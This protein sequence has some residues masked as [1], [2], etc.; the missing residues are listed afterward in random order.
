VTF[1]RNYPTNNSGSTPVFYEAR[2]RQQTI[3]T[4]NGTL[5]G[6]NHLFGATFDWG[7][8][9][10]QSGNS[11]PFDYYVDF[12]ENQGRRDS[13]GHVNSGMDIPPNLFIHSDPGQII[14][15]AVNNFQA[16]TMD[17]GIYSYEKNKQI[18]ETAYLDG[19]ERYILG[20]WLSGEF[21]AGAKFKY[22]T[23]YKE[24]S[25]LF[26]PYYLGFAWQPKD[27]TGTRFAGFYTRYLEQGLRSPLLTDFLDPSPASRNVFDQFRLYPLMNKDAVHDW[28]ELNENGTAAA[29]EY[30]VDNTADL[31]YYDIIERIGAGYAMNTLNFGQDLTLITGLRAE[32]ESNDYKSR[33]VP[34][35]GSLGGFPT[36]TGQTKDTTTSYSETVWLPNVHLVIRP[37]DFMNVR[38]AAYKAL[39]RPDFNARLIKLYGQG[40]GTGTQVYLGNPF[41]RDSKAWN[42][43]L[44]TSV[45]DNAIGLVSISAYY[46]EI[47]DDIHFLNSAGLTGPGFIDS[48]GIHWTTSLTKGSYQLTIPYNASSPTKVWGFEFEHQA[49]LGFLPGYLQFLVLSYNFSVIRS[50]THLIATTIDT[51]FSADTT[52]FGVVI[53]PS[54]SNRIIDRKQKLEG[55]PEFLANVVLGYDLG[56]FSARVSFYYQG[57]FNSTFSAGGLTD[58]VTGRYTRLDLALKQRITDNVSLLLNVNNLLDVEEDTYTTNRVYNWTRLNTSQRYGT[59]ADFG[60]MVNL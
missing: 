37:F 48:L 52:E 24:A 1:D 46:K 45:F 29:N 40:T 60:V 9:H 3:A 15:Y 8:A 6:E 11:Y 51:T 38:L 2:D 59:T 30:Y 44:N 35:T 5:H 20:D 47:T 41:L 39:A 33:F 17:S 43:E 13:T 34:G 57:E 19:K 53:T 58:G 22:T 27:L 31:D 21:K 54:Y 28:Y 16:T 56:G 7:L 55:Q 42:Y 10:A 4:F 14:P 32:R 12:F 23:R 25:R 49:N 36:P 18:E 26:A 50:E